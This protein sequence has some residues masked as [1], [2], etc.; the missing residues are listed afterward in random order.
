MSESQWLE[1][2]SSCRAWHARPGSFGPSLCFRK[3]AVLASQSGETP[4]MEAGRP[5][6]YDTTDSEKP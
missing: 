2:N 6:D 1:H 3:T 5:F 4:R